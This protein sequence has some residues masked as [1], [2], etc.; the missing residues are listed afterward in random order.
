[1]KG[2]AVG[3]DGEDTANAALVEALERALGRFARVVKSYIRDLAVGVHPELRQA[4]WIVMGTVLRHATDAEPVAVGDIVQMTGM[5][6]SVVSRQLR[7][8][9]DWGLVTMRRSD[10]DA[11][12][13]LVAPTDEA[14][15]RA[16]A[17]RRRRRDVT[18]RLLADW[19]DDDLERLSELLNRLIDSV[20]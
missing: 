9:K 1:M 3:P 6:K 7:S 5:D 19:S 4:G 10:E 17:V 13:V 8:L 18:A 20:D 12:V 15:E 14:L 2:M 11:R 16:E